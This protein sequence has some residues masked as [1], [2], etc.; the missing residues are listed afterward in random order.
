M[1]TS[2]AQTILVLLQL[3]NDMTP[4]LLADFQ[5]GKVTDAQQQALLD[6]IA[7]IPD[8]FTGPEWKPTA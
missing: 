6:A 3:I 1:N 5:S 8:D 4:Q 7:K 2:T